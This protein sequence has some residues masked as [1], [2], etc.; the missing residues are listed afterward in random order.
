MPMRLAM[1]LWVSK[2]GFQALLD[3]ADHEVFDLCDRQVQL[4]EPLDMAALVPN[5]ARFEVR[6]VISNGM[7]EARDSTAWANDVVTASSSY[8]PNDPINCAM[9]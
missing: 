6:R 4:T 9:W 2:K 7:F 5:R 1:K 3:G 8:D